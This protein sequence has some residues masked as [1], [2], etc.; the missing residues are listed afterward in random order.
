MSDLVSGFTAWVNN[1]T[2][3]AGPVGRVRWDGG[4]D[5]L[6]R[7]V[8]TELQRQ[9]ALVRARD[10]QIIALT[11]RLSELQDTPDD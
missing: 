6:A 10:A 5:Y 11:A 1:K 3:E 4:D 7:E 9:I 8:A 2:R